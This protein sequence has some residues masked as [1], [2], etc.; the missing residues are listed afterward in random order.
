MKIAVLSPRSEFSKD[1]I[2]RLESLGETI[3]VEKREEYPV[4]K[5]IDISK[6]ADILAVDP[7]VCGGFEKAKSNLTEII[8]LLP[9]LK[10]VC[11]GTTS[12]GWIDLEYCKKRKIPVSNCPGWSRESVA[13]QTITFILCAVRRVILSDREAQKGKY[14]LRISKEVKGKTLGIIGLG[15]I[16]SRVAE[17]AHGIGMKVIAY[18][19]SPKKQTNVEMKS[20]DEVLHDSDIISLHITHEPANENLIDQKALSKTKKGIVFVNLCDRTA[21]DETAMAQA[22]KSGQVGTYILELEKFDGS[23]IS[24]LEN[25]IMMKPFA[26]FTKEALDRLLELWVENIER[27]AKNSPQNIVS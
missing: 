26:W 22:V 8:E 10:G 25:V 23:P 3:Y 14:E 17:L 15:S 12:F 11:L 5:L 24:G 1:Q 6:D 18:N 16:G 4:E 27:M 19:R 7:D 20:L 21:I 9:H 13:E 2:G